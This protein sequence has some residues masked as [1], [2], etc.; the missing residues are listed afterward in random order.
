LRRRPVGKEND[1][2]AREK[3]FLG[4]EMILINE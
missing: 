1:I 3:L 2:G 4:Y